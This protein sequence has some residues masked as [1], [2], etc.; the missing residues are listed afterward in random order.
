MYEV[1]I[2][3]DEASR[4]WRENKISTGN[5]TYKY[6]CGATRKDGGKCKNAPSTGKRYCHIHDPKTKSQ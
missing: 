4:V 3:F 6:I 5:G 2:D 1:N